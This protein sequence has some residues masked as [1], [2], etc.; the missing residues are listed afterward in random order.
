MKHPLTLTTFALALLLASCGGSEGASSSTLP[1]TQPEESSSLSSQSSEDSSETSSPS[2][3]ETTSESSLTSETSS[4]ESSSDET[5]SSS[6]ESSVSSEES[7]SIEESSSEES[8]SVEEVY[9]IR[10]VTSGSGFSVHFLDDAL[11]LNDVEPETEISFT[12]SPLADYYVLSGVKA[13]IDRGPLTLTET[14]GVYSFVM[15]YYDVTITVT[16]TRLY[17][18]ETVAEHATVTFLNEIKPYYASGERIRFTAVPEEG[19]VLD[20]VRYSFSG[21]DGKLTADSEG[22]YEFGMPSSQATITCVTSAVIDSS[23][24]PWAGKSATYTGLV[25]NDTDYKSTFTISF[26]GNGTFDFR[27]DT[28]EYYDD[29]GE[30]YEAPIPPTKREWTNNAGWVTDSN[31]TYAYLPEQNCFSAEVNCHQ[32]NKDTLTFSVSETL[33]DGVPAS[34]TLLKDIGSDAYV[35][36]KNKVLT[37]Q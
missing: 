15:P 9:G 10:L 24:D 14:E 34:I 4:L 19:Y 29:W 36:C 20:E 21:Y 5:S 12:L 33:V 7:S 16:G 13:T 37:L 11:D 8:S 26:K 22:I 25:R 18:V 6:E 27:V 35:R 30:W 3:E 23:S 31:V 17:G 28:Q 32:Q 2:L 1:S